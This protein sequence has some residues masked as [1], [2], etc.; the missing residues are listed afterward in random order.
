MLSGMRHLLI[1]VAL[2]PMPALAVAQDIYLARITNTIAGV[3]AE[4]PVNITNRA[5]YDNQPSF[6]PDGRAILYTSTREDAQADIYRYD[7]TTKAIARLTK[8]VPESEYSAVVMPR[9]DRFSVIRVEKDSAQRIWS[10]DLNGEGPQVEI[11]GVKPVGY[12]VWPDSSHVAMFVL[13][14][15]NTLR[16]A[17]ARGTAVDSVTTS[18]GRGLVV[19]GRSG[20]F[21]FTR[22]DSVGSGF[23]VHA[24]RVDTK[25]PQMSPAMFPLPAGCEYF[26]VLNGRP[27]RP[28]FVTGQGSKLLAREGTTGGEWTEIA[29][30]TS[31][32]LTRISRLA[33]SPDG[34]WI[35]IV[36]EPRP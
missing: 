16:V 1:A 31:S 33:I 14:T 11:P 27:G 26:V 8:T 23:S 22:R 17:D 24:A 21:F 7:I 5:G 35:A 10:F 32:G 3:R 30:F 29:D 15:P 2:L 28:V 34:Q 9:G 18:I 20:Q 13:G 19:A 6:T 12:H 25:P 4:T 36:A